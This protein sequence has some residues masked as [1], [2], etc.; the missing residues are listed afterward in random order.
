MNSLVQALCACSIFNA[1]VDE[2]LDLE[3]DVLNDLLQLEEQLQLQQKIELH[4]CL[5]LFSTNY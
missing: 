2:Y 1:V 4:L 5:Q 3:N